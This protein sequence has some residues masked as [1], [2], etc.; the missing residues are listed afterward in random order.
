MRARA[1]SLSL[2]HTH[3]HQALLSAIVLAYFEYVGKMGFRFAHMRVPPPTD[4]SRFFTFSFTPVHYS[5]TFIITFLFYTFMHFTFPCAS[6]ESQIATFFF[7]ASRAMPT[8][9]ESLNPTST[10]SHIFASRSVAVRLR[11][12]LHLSHWSVCVCV[13]ERERE[14]E[15]GSE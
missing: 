4:D 1:R 9:P 11:A 10:C 8:W 5:L 14:R 13:C 12:S 2:T 7:L 15:R 6:R 3:T